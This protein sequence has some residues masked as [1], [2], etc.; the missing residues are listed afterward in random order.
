MPSSESKSLPRE[1]IGRILEKVTAKRSESARERAR[2]KLAALEA[3]EKGAESIRPLREQTQAHLA[4][5]EALIVSVEGKSK[6]T[7]T[8]DELKNMVQ[9]LTDLETELS[10]EIALE[11]RRFEIEEQLKGDL[12]ALG[13]S[14]IPTFIDWLG[15]LKE[16]V[17]GEKKD[18]KNIHAENLTQFLDVIIAILNKVEL[19]KRQPELIKEFE[20][21]TW[22]MPSGFEETIDIFSGKPGQTGKLDELLTALETELAASPSQSTPDVSGGDHGEYEL[23]GKNFVKGQLYDIGAEKSSMQ[24]QCVGGTATGRPTFKVIS[25]NIPGQVGRTMVPTEKDIEKFTI[26][27]VRSERQ[28]EEA[29]EGETIEGEFM[30]A[31]KSLKTDGEYILSIQSG[32]NWNDVPIVAKHAE[33]THRGYSL[34]Y[35]KAQRGAAKSKPGSISD[36]EIKNGRAKIRI[37]EEYDA[38]QAALAAAPRE[39]AGSKTVRVFGQDRTLDAAGRVE[40][41]DEEKEPKNKKNLTEGLGEFLWD[42][43]RAILRLADR[44]EMSLVI[45]D[46][47]VPQVKQ[48]RIE[49]GQT[50]E[51][52]IFVYDTP[53]VKALYR[54]ELHLENNPNA[55]KGAGTRETFFD[56]QTGLVGGS[57]RG[58]EG[59]TLS[60]SKSGRKGFGDA[61]EE[62][63]AAMKKH[64]TSLSAETRATWKEAKK[65]DKQTKQ[66]EERLKDGETLTFAGHSFVGGETY[67]LRSQPVLGDFRVLGVEKD[68]NTLK[69]EGIERDGKRMKIQWLKESDVQSGPWVPV[70]QK[71]QERNP[72]DVKK[73][74]KQEVFANFSQLFQVSPSKHGLAHEISIRGGKAGRWRRQDVRQLIEEK[75]RR[76]D[77]VADPRGVSKEVIIDLFDEWF[78]QIAATIGRKAGE[79]VGRD[80][81]S[82]TDVK[83]I[84]K[85]PDK[86]REP[87]EF[88]ERMRTRAFSRFDSV[89]HVRRTG[90]N[91]GFEVYVQLK[92]GYSK[93]I[94]ADDIA[95]KIENGKFPSVQRFIE[96]N[97]ISHEKMV[98]FFREWFQTVIDD[99][100]PAP[101]GREPKPAPADTSRSQPA[102]SAQDERKEDNKGEIVW[103][104]DAV[105]TPDGDWLRTYIPLEILYE[106]PDGRTK[107]VKPNLPDAVRLP[108]SFSG[109]TMEEQL[110]WQRDFI[111]PASKI[112]WEDPNQSRSKGPDVAVWPAP[113]VVQNLQPPSAVNEP[114]PTVESEPPSPPQPSQTRESRIAAIR[115]FFRSKRKR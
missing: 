21:D 68:G 38:D 61:I 50:I 29:K 75:F 57:M 83:P 90:D 22:S 107:V 59:F 10:T 79:P 12:R 100:G 108:K 14:E 2:E 3:L 15:N 6:A 33:K 77:F 111:L 74:I 76:D 114:K 69:V 95:R 63:I 37:R 55:Y 20:T 115:A 99:M 52:V 7:A 28:E 32:S 96:K 105:A 84:D 88:E 48:P 58:P 104:L 23:A 78:D 98:E 26:L 30:F 18:I 71:R 64:V 8:T 91:T 86:S 51:P 85:E 42:D 34:I 93:P 53:G 82:I 60:I 62:A 80:V 87:G 102:D 1:R 46:V 16:E 72:D 65:V 89:F 25:S 35:E 56:H 73:K 41:R 81:K 5:L 94:T 9:I 70:E 11:K 24:V 97:N 66:P 101:A 113:D 39:P 45:P 44:E 103:T 67:R 106:L 110:Q 31:D 49:K 36:E 43:T 40:L 47:G 112:I 17:R 27:P 54:I 109:L 4:A 92:D 13:L 19:A